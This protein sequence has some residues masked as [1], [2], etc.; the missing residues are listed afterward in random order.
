MRRTLGR[1]VWWVLAI[2]GVTASLVASSVSYAAP[3]PIGAH[4]GFSQGGGVTV[5][6]PKS[7][8]VQ[9][10][11]WIAL[12]EAGRV[13]RP[14]VGQA[15]I[16]M[17]MTPTAGYAPAATAELL[18][19]GTVTSTIEAPGYGNDDHGTYYTDGYFWNFCGAGATNTALYYWNGHTSNYGANTYTEPS[20]AGYHSSTYW[21]SG[22]HGRSYEMYLAM[23]VL[24][25]GWST[26]GEVTF[27]SYPSAGTYVNDIT[28]TM[29]W[30][31][32]GENSSTWN[33]YFYI[34]QADDSAVTSQSLHNSVA[35]DVYYSRAPVVIMVNTKDLPNWAGTNKALI[36]VV[37]IIGYDDSQGI[38]YYTDTCGTQCGSNHNGGINTISQ[39]QMY[40]ALMDVG[41][42]GGYVW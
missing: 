29:N 23:K 28:S 14:I 42:G 2:V 34:T 17:P 31:A 19:T 15:P 7:H 33:N 38:Y 1:W 9:D 22:D 32:S 6:T 18:Y 27:F 4:G 8:N 39:S 20:Y 36:H 25:P 26:T 35:Q 30:E 24:V 5:G 40:K 13:V 16:I 11:R 3:R 12:K 41:G 37:T 10:P 21:T